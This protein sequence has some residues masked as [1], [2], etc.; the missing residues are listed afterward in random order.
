MEHSSAASPTPVEAAAAPN[1][2]PEASNVAPLAAT[3]ASALPAGAAVAP[4]RFD[5]HAA[6]D[7]N[8]NLRLSPSEDG[9]GGAL[10]FGGA[11]DPLPLADVP[12][13]PETAALRRKA[14]LYRIPSAAE[15]E[16]VAAA[17]AP[18]P[19]AATPV[20]ETPAA[21]PPV[22]PA[23]AAPPAA[24][25]AD[26]TPAAAPAAAAPA[27]TPAAVPTPAAA[28]L[29]PHPEPTTTP[30]E[31]RPA[32][33][34]SCDAMP[35][36]APVQKP[37]KTLIVTHLECANH[38]TPALMGTDYVAGAAAPFASPEQPERVKAVWA[39]LKQCAW[40]CG[41]T[42]IVDTV[43][44]ATSPTLNRGLNDTLER[45]ASPETGPFAGPPGAPKRQ[46]PT[47]TASVEFLFDDL[48]P[49]VFCAEI[50]Q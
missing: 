9:W 38:V 37:Q 11:D 29:A 35:P 24:T 28:P 10:A 32:P 36:P 44:L 33:A 31:T 16:A 13:N 41:G 48:E 22:A 17:P 25:P 49:V 47:R 23:A 30:A 12:G 43:E 19:A 18:A 4:P 5:L 50:N 42:K 8:L 40:T 26:A 6:P 15:L 20:A 21:A 7:A 34:P 3:E 2:A 1:P 27:A 14:A 46:S 39:A 45:F